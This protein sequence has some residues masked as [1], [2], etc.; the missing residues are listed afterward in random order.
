MNSKAAIKICIDTADMVCGAYLGDLT[1]SEMM[2]RP[3]PACNH[4]NW[5]VGHLI[6]AEHQMM[7]KAQGYSMPP[8][9]A[10]MAEMYSKETQGS[11]DSSQFMTKS[12]LMATMQEQ[13]A[14]TLKILDQI[15]EADLD[16]ATGIDYAPTIASLLSM[17]GSHWMMHAG[18]W[19]IVRRNLGKAVLI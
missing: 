3:H 1:D 13:R 9:P 2:Q 18:Q 4:I 5:Q 15:S 8:L 10:G 12:A 17:Q 7:S 14:G 11:D 6:V 19:V 16:T